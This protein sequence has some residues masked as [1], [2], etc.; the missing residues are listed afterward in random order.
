MTIHD[1]IE[2]NYKIRAALSYA[3]IVAREE[4]V[5]SPSGRA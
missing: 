1:R 5:L 2:I 3:D 4:I